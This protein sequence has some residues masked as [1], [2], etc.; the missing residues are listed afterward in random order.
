MYLRLIFGVIST[1]IYLVVSFA[2]GYTFYF[3]LYYP[4]LLSNIIDCSWIYVGMENMAP[5]VVKNI[6]AKLLTMLGVFVLVRSTGDVW[7]YILLVA[8]SSLLCNLAVYAQLKEI[9][10][11]PV[12][13]KAN[14]KNHIQGSIY[15]FL[16]QIASLI[17]LQ[18]DKTMLGTITGATNEV[19]FYDQAEKLVTNIAFDLRQSYGYDAKISK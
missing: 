1:V 4:F 18:M 6:I 15:L 8:G 14:I 10:K 5:C 13:D 16:P 3:L 19:S 17:Y 12:I 7:K 9:I 11:K 2:S